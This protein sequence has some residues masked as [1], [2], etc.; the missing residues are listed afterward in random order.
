MP[1]KRRK[2]NQERSVSKR[3]YEY[4]KSRVELS[5]SIILSCRE[6]CRALEAIKLDVNSQIIKS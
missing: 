6:L 1:L 4:I 3:T 2:Y 5:G